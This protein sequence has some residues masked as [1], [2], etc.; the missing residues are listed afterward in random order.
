MAGAAR[1]ASTQAVKMTEIQHNDGCGVQDR[2]R[3]R[4]AGPDDVDGLH[5]LA[6]LP[7]VYR[8]L[9]DGVAPARAFIAQRV[10]QS[11]GNPATATDM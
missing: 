4:G 7:P 2:W 6:C 8:Y 5:A 1:F 3:L 11:I 9:F 10:A